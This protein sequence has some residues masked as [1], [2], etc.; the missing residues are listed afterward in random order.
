[1]TEFNE[2]E[3]YKIIAEK[4][5]IEPEKIAD[6]L[7]KTLV[8]MGADSLDIEEMSMDFED[9]YN[10]SINNE[11]AGAINPLNTINIVRYLRKKIKE[12]AGVGR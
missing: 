1:M 4:L 7:E 5:G 10:I 2:Q 6:N 8:D 12:K 3:I 9:K 11:E